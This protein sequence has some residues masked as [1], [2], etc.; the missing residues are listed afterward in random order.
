MKNEKQKDKNVVIKM[1]FDNMNGT[2]VQM[3]ITMIYRI[4]QMDEIDQKDTIC[5]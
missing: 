2:K 3:N 1:K 5:H 4:Y